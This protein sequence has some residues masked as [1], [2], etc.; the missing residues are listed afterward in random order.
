MCPLWNR[1]T[2]DKRSIMV[3]I[4]E[5]SKYIHTE[6]NSMENKKNNNKDSTLDNERV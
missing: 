5:S 2:V 3:M 6:A 1:G 4:N